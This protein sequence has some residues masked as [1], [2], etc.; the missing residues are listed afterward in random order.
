MSSILEALKKSES[1]RRLG[2]DPVYRG[3]GRSPGPVLLRWVSLAAGLLLLLALLLAA[4][5]IAG[6]DPPTVTAPAAG[7]NA[8]APAPVAATSITAATG[9]PAASVPRLLQETTP[10]ELPSARQ[11]PVLADQTQVPAG[12]PATEPSRAPAVGRPATA[13]RVEGAP[14]LSS[15]PDNF[16]KSLP[17]LI[18]NIHVYTPDS[19]DRILYINN[20]PVRPGGTTAGGVVVEEIVP[21]GVVLRYHGQRFKLPRP[22]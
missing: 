19:N 17:P 12:S 22:S 6:R 16:R 8:A 20:R 9:A 3:A 14:W 18:V 7:P 21:E 1:R 13:A 11:T 2:Q 15:L 4:Q 5:L 10:A